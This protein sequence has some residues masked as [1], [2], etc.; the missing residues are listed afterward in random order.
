[1]LSRTVNTNTKKC[2]IGNTKNIRQKARTKI[3]ELIT[4]RC[5]HF[6][7]CC[8]QSHRRVAKQLMR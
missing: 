4:G 1:M 6:S 7:R 3:F 8:K 2:C 5:K